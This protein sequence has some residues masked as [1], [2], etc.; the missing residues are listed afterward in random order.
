MDGCG[1]QAGVR[2][3]PPDTGH[4]S[5]GT[6][7]P[8]RHILVIWWDQGPSGWLVRIRFGYGIMRV[9]GWSISDLDYVDVRIMLEQYAHGTGPLTSL[10]HTLMLR[11]PEHGLREMGPNRIRISHPDVPDSLP[12]YSP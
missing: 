6:A 3:S 9:D 10:D 5:G 8:I 4:G 7:N 11:I 2:T 1:W 12:S